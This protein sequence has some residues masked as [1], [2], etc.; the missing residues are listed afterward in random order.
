MVTESERNYMGSLWETSS[1][2]R[3][4]VLT[5]GAE[6]RRRDHVENLGADVSKS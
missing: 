2:E 4:C 5:F 6:T 1:G 3:K